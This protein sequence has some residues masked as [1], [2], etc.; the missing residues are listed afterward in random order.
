MMM[1]MMMMI[2]I[3]IERFA[4]SETK[5]FREKLSRL[6]SVFLYCFVYVQLFLL[7]LSVLV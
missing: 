1:M 5:I 2:I 3:I 7:L 4:T 6:P